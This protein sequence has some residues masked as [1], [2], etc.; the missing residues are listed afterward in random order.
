MM[1]PN[2]YWLGICFEGGGMESL[3]RRILTEGKILDGAILKVDSFIN[4]QVD[5]QL[6]DEIGEE[7]HKRFQTYGVDKVLT[8]ETSGIPAAYAAA[9]RFNVPFVFAKKKASGNLDGDIL[10]T[11]VYS[12]TKACH[13][14]VVVSK[15]YLN[16]GEKVL[17][18]DDFL[19]NGQAALGLIDLV[20]QAGAEAVGVAAIIE[21]AFQEGGKRIRAHGV[22]LESLAS[23]LKMDGQGI[24]ID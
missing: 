24:V 2:L 19:A 23:I 18:V 17:I 13:Y 7:I 1:P 8:I 12:Y 10:K 14:D 22:R 4:H 20:E 15:A 21:K 9:R 16:A 3:K 6:M 11:R 5:P